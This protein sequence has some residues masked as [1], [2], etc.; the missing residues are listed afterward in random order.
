MVQNLNKAILTILFL[1]TSL[2]ILFSQGKPYEGPDDPAADIAA[3]REG[4]MA[5]NRVNTYFQNSTEISNCCGVEYSKWP[6][7]FNG[8]PMTDGIGLLISAKVYVEN[9]TIPVDD[10]LLINN[11]SD[12]QEI[13]FLQTSYRE[14]MDKN[15]EGTLEWG[16]YP[17]FGY[18]DETSEHPAMSNRPDSW[19]P[20]GW[21]SRG[22][23]R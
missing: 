23:D 3:K 9:D 20:A 16:F 4:W 1:F 21:P 12:L 22:N 18:F 14:R 17:V 7:D 5:G 2:T 15:P 11:Q 6:N 19:P 8:Q 10:P 13:Y